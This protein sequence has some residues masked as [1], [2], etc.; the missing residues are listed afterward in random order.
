LTKELVL[1]DK[2]LAFDE[3]NFHCWNYR[4]FIR[5][6]QKKQEPDEVN[7]QKVDEEFSRKLI[8]ENFS[9][10]SAWHLRTQLR[11]DL[12]PLNSEL[13]YLKQGLYTE[14]ND[15]SIWL[16]YNWL[17]F[18][19]GEPLPRNDETCAENQ[20]RNSISSNVSDDIL[21][22]ELSVLQELLDIEPESKYCLLTM[23]NIL[24][25]LNS[26]VEDRINIWKQLVDLDPIRAGYYTSQISVIDTNTCH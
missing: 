11:P 23:T 14:P 6:L 8:N 24:K 9:N 15:Q 16:Y 13:E 5:T 1:C 25:A 20:L 17:L 26:P 18:R 22:K 7:F 19:R 21:R 3:R 2:F 10:Y 12:I 4:Q